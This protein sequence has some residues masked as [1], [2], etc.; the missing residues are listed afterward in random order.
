MMNSKIVQASQTHGARGSLAEISKVVSC[1]WFQRSFEPAISDVSCRE[2]CGVAGSFRR[3]I[4]RGRLT[5]IRPTL[6]CSDDV[7]AGCAP[8]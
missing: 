3:R 5:C 7:W 6:V 2:K 4:N 1:S 8:Q